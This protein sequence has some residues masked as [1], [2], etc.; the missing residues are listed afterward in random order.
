MKNFL[1]GATLSIAVA[2]V[3][4][5]VTKKND[6]DYIEIPRHRKDSASK[7]MES[8]AN[9]SRFERPIITDR[10]ILADDITS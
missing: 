1:I 2:A 9:P 5:R 4:K 7:L 10:G 3:I 6:K 8:I